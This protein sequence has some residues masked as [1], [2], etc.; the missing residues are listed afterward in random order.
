LP[1]S[2]HSDRKCCSISRQ[3]RRPAFGGARD[4]EPLRQLH[5][6]DE[7]EHHHRGNTL[8]ALPG[9]IG[10]PSEAAQVTTLPTERGP[11]PVDDQ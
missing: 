2:R 9:T 4:I 11:Q 5:L 1:A 8:A 6:R 3:L 7:Q 10:G